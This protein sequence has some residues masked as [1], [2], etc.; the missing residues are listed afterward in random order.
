M[1]RRTHL[2]AA[3]AALAAAALLSGCVSI[4]SSGP[5][6]QGLAIAQDSGNPSFEVNPE[7]PA[8]NASQRDLL[9][10]FI[11]AFQSSTGGY[12]VAREYLTTA[13][14]AKWDPT[15]VVQVR[16]GSP[17]YLQSDDRTI[18]YAFTTSATVNASGAY[19]Q[20]TAPTS[21][22][23]GFTRVGTQWRI[24]SAPN[25]IVLSDQAFQ[26]LFSKHALYFLDPSSTNLVPDLRWFPN[27]TAPT[28]VVSALLAGPA[29]WLA[30][31]AR[32]EFPDG[33]ELSQAGSLVTVDAGV[34][35]VDLT[36]EAK[37]AGAR[38]RQLMLL[39][40][41][42]SLRTVPNI[43][44]VTISVEGVPLQI[45]DLGGSGP[46]VEPKVDAQAL[47]Y[48]GG[49]FGF[50]ANNKV[51]GLGSLGSK[52]ASLDPIA[53]TLSSDGSTVAVLGMQ[54]SDRVVSVVKKSNSAVTVLDSRP[55][56]IPPTMDE[57]GYIWTVPA[58][59]PNAA[60]AYDAAGVSHDVPL[61]LP[62]D[63]QVVSMQIS[64]DGARIAI[65]L[66]SSTGPRLI[67]AAILR[68]AKYAPTGIGPSIVDTGLDSGP[69]IGLTWEDQLTVATLVADGGQSRVD[70]FVIGG[71]S[72]Q[73]GDPL[74]TSVSIVGGNGQA[75]LRV[76]GADSAVYSY[77][78]STWQSTGAKVTFIATQR[79]LA[80]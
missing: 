29:P 76:L 67:V 19:S 14:A 18:D 17:R 65:L 6:T 9:A 48:R 53:A 1:P 16:T 34:A 58:G 2:V 40:L 79:G 55:G 12:A 66:Q 23:F 8:R 73:L 64:R 69:A 70:E 11:A 57:N 27:G 3:A 30:G 20:G 21:L 37:S 54:G 47:V 15:Q 46:Q 25:G 51:G 44:S 5:A 13:F 68:D 33:T 24:S 7:G 36:A 52:V 32:S 71:A 39:Q 10:G 60:H 45:D 26:R 62:A 28:R 31:A 41:E 77:P 72:A 63:A 35:R 43:S 50:Y 78:G 56:L 42:D 22:E 38:E 80:N 61:S 75:G 4:P 74:A 59:S 49:E